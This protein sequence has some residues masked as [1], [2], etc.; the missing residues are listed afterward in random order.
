MRFDRVIFNFPDLA[1]VSR[2]FPSPLTLD[3]D[4]KP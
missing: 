1:E 2:W 3:P 4:P